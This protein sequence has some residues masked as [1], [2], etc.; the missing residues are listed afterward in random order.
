MDKPPITA[1]SL[2]YTLLFSIIIVFISFYSSH[3]DQRTTI[4]FCDVGQGDAA[5]IRIKNKID[6]VI[7]GGPDKKVLQCLGKYMPFYDRKIELAFITHPQ[8]DHFYGFNYLT[9]RYQIDKFYLSPIDNPT[10]QSFQTLKKKINNKKIPILIATA[11]TEIKIIND[12]I[13]FLWP[14]NEFLENN[15][16][17]SFDI[18]NYSLVFI[19]KENDFRVLFTGDASSLALSKLLHQNNLKTDILKI[20]H[21]GSKNGLIKEFLLLADPKVSV[22]SVGKN[23]SYGHPHQEVLTML[24]AQKTNIMRTDEKGDIVFKLKIKSKN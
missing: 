7:D 21:H 14:A 16:K 23:N 22:I 18:N 4:V 15:K 9:D 12:N 2:I 10:N 11:G 17:K 24:K 5:Y 6:I 3:F 1:K 19:F 13:Q 8:K 20:P